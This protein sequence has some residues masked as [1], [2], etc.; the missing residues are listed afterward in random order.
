MESNEKLRN[1]RERINEKEKEREIIE[2]LWI[3]GGHARKR[4]M[5]KT[6]KKK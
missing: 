2:M 6:K 5:R 1:E 4:N 3:E